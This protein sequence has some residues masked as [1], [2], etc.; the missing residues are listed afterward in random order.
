[1]ENEH[2]P[3]PF[4]EYEPS[5]T[6][7]NEDGFLMMSRSTKSD[8]RPSMGTLNKRNQH[9]QNNHRQSSNYQQ[10]NRNH[11]QPG[12]PKNQNPRYAPYNQQ[13]RGRGER[14]H[15]NSKSFKQTP[16]KEVPIEKFVTVQMIMNPWEEFENVQYEGVYD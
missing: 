3:T 6:D 10:Q 16:L 5:N 4:N 2:L 7:S 15:N 9:Y 11:F 14:S 1:M 12:N 13:N 8:Y